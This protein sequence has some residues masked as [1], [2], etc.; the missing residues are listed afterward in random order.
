MARDGA[1][2]L[3]RRRPSRPENFLGQPRQS[4]HDALNPRLRRDE[5]TRRLGGVSASADADNGALV[6]ADSPSRRSALPDARS[7]RHP[8]F[9]VQHVR[10]QKAAVAESVH[11]VTFCRPALHDHLVH[12]APGATGEDHV[13]NRVTRVDTPGGSHLPEV[14]IGLAV[15]R[16]CR[17]HEVSVVEQR[18][19]RLQLLQNFNKFSGVH[20][21]WTLTGF[22]GCAACYDV[23]PAARRPGGPCGPD[24]SDGCSPCTAAPCRGG[25]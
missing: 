6:V 2:A 9:L 18:L 15:E 11:V 14:I 12:W 5:I 13:P 7:S 20:R 3:G 1:V 10:E 22:G 17:V 16:L 25:R 19:T 21:G 8:F 4:L 24:R 23:V